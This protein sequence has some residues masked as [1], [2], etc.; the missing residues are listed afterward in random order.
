VQQPRQPA[1]PVF[2]A[3]GGMLLCLPTPVALPQAMSAL[4]AEQRNFSMRIKIGPFGGA[5]HTIAHYCWDSDTSIRTEDGLKDISTSP[6]HPSVPWVLWR[7][8]VAGPTPYSATPY[9]GLRRD[10]TQ[11]LAYMQVDA[12]LEIITDF[13]REGVPVFM[14]LAKTLKRF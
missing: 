14:W 2:H 11:A 12:T 13:Q 5:Q 1:L 4:S 3:E 10:R 6:C 7:S 9:P 8:M